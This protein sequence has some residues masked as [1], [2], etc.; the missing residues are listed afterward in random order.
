M[1]KILQFKLSGKFAHFKFPFTSPNFLKKS[2]TIPPRTTILGLLGSIIGLDGFQQYGDEAKEPEYYEKLK[3]I[4]IAVTL[5]KIPSKQL[6]KYNSL[7]SFANNSKQDGENV[8]IKEE[9]LL[10]PE[11]NITLLLDDSIEE[12]KEIIKCINKNNVKSKYHIYL[13]KNEFFAN[14]NEVEIYS[15]EDFTLKEYKEIEKLSS[16][17]PLNLLNDG[18][19]YENLVYDSFSRNIN[20]F[21]KRLKTERCEVGYFIFGKDKDDDE[22]DYIKFQKPVELLNLNN[23]FYYFFKNEK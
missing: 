19:A 14:I 7:N 18:I 3:H 12:D 22:I 15:S 4:P 17:I 8:I 11:Y 10:N 16:I 23:N 9:I 20:F 2:F 21:E 6:I 13:G 1:Q 5:N